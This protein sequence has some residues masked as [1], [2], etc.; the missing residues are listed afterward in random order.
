M[1]ISL[2]GFMGCGKS[3][4]GRELQKIIGCSL[5]DLDDYIEKLEGRSVKEIFSSEGEAAFR[6]MELSALKEIVARDNAGS[7]TVLSLGGGT[8]M[9]PDCEAI[10]RSSTVNFYLSASIDTLLNNLSGGTESRPV[11]AASEGEDLRERISGLME[12]RHPVY[13]RAAD[14]IIQTDGKAPESVAKEIA[15]MILTPSGVADQPQN[16]KDKVR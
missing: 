9:T 1:I 11:L 10:V 12:R 7:R 14:H 13:M 2:S 6:A 8:L 5:E 16:Q 15:G 4:V 3:S